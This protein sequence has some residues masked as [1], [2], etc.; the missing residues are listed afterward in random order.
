MQSYICM[1]LHIFK[2]TK[3]AGDTDNDTS[4]NLPCNI[5]DKSTRMDPANKDIWFKQEILPHEQPLR[6]WLHSRYGV[7]PILDD[8]VQESYIRLLRAYETREIKSPRSYLFRIA[9]N[10]A[11]DFIKT[12]SKLKTEPLDNESENTSSDT[13]KN[14]REW[15]KHEEELELLKQ[16]IAQLPNKCRKIFILRRFKG[17][18]SAEIAQQMGISTHTVSAQLTIALK[19]CA[20]FFESANE[21]NTRKSHE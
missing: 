2:L 14:S 19:K 18:P 4:T 11:I 6:A 21:S 3:S 17:M 12:D 16:A 13:Y 15:A 9:S 5:M 8:V 1:S 10:V 7:G 20:D